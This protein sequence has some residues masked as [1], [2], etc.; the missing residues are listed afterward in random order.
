MTAPSIKLAHTLIE[1]LVNEGVR[2]FILCPGSRSAPLAFVLAELADAGVI[3][4]RVETDERVAGFVAL[5]SGLTGKVAA[6]VTTS[7][8]AVANLH[9]A[10]EEAFYAGVPMIVLSADRPLEMR[11]VRA[12]QTTDHR[13]VLAGSI[14]HFVELA[15]EAADHQIRGQVQRIV[16]HAR[17]IGIGAAPGPTQINVA[18]REPL[19]PDGG[20][21][22][23]GRFMRGSHHGSS[24]RDGRNEN[25]LSGDASAGRKTVVVAGPSA[26][27]IPL[28][29]TLFD[30]LP[31]F[32]EPSAQL[33]AHRNAVP[34]H[35]L[36]LESELAEEIER[37]IV[38]GHP[39]LT[40][41]VSGLLASA[42]REI[43][44]LDDAPTFTD[45]SGRGRVIDDA[46]VRELAVDADF[47]QRV[48]EAGQ[49]SEAEITHILADATD[50]YE[51]ARVA[52]AVAER[53]DTVA[54][55]VGASS[56]IREMNLYAPAPGTPV[57]AN[58]G[59]AGIDGTI[60][61]ATGVGLAT[62]KPVRVVL[63]DLTFIHDLGALV[64]GVGESVVDLDIVVIDD[65]GGSLFA[66]LEYGEQ[67]GAHYDRIFRTARR[68]DIAEYA[69][70][71][72]VDCVTV[73]QMKDLGPVLDKPWQ[74]RR[75]VHVVMPTRTVEQQRE[76]RNRLRVALGERERLGGALPR[77]N[78]DNS[79]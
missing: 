12:N 44:V 22:T 37:V 29:A 20:F 23:D 14:R 5:G 47:T 59:L 75:I 4:L 58:R 50:G 43:L 16:R 30:G 25:V 35:P 6:V 78:P 53:A 46:D 64:P 21:M 39:T 10:C 45:V 52:R 3:T 63:G 28:D 60:S 31:I 40:R 42:H 61:T 24:W 79:N 19:M 18:L 38:V 51:F 48:I 36:L 62:G 7:G 71:T 68:F 55:L 2:T 8:T 73:T 56:I 32:A 74:G 9:P 57:Y 67:P 65:G 54:T 69:V 34:A 11:G 15:P 27:A 70:A 1:A 76:D 33:R 41:Q 72:G 13:A 17:G 26:R 49:E 77:K 66:T